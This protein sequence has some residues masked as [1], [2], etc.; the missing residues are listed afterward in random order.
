MLINC[1]ARRLRRPG[2]LET[3][4]DR[5][6]PVSLAHVDQTTAAS[7]TRVRRHVPEEAESLLKGRFQI[8]N[9]WR[10]IGNQAI[11]W[12]IGLCDYRSVDMGKDFFPVTTLFPTHVG[13][14][15]AVKYNPN[16]QWKYQRG[17][18]PDEIV[19]IKW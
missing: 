17:M 6:Q 10:P 4:S 18:T 15:M 3:S 9:L 11:D 14:T 7:I 1:T 12:P 5:R 19:L 8:I 2:E 16:H 13:E